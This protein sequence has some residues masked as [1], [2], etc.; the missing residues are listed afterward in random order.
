[1]PIP[2]P[3]IQ[4]LQ[5]GYPQSDLQ[6]VMKDIVPAKHW[7]QS[8]EDP[9]TCAIRLSHAFNHAKVPIRA[10]SGVGMFKGN[11]DLRYIYR[12]DEFVDYVTA[13]Y[14]KPDITQTSRSHKPAEIRQAIAGSP[15]VL[16][17]KLARTR[18]GK[19]VDLSAFGHADIW[20]GS[21]VWY[22]PTV[23]DRT[24]HVQLW[25]V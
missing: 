25:T 7:L 20:D 8:A 2:G 16:F 4:T 17:F 23:W 24:W 3:T 19:S 14:G 11:D 13:L 18:K 21:T 12:A 22:N 15:G 10:R 9:N 5:S 6:T 1:M